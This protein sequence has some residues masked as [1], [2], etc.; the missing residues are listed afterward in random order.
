MTKFPRLKTEVFVVLLDFDIKKIAA[1]R[2]I[3]PNCIPIL[4]V[5]HTRVNFGKRFKFSLRKKK[6][7]TGAPKK[8]SKHKTEVQAV[9]SDSDSDDECNDDDS[10]E[11]EGGDDKEED[12]RNDQ[13]GGVSTMVRCMRCNKFRV[14]SEATALLA[15]AAGSGEAMNVGE[16]VER[17]AQFACDSIGMSCDTPEDEGMSGILGADT[18]E[19]ILVRHIFLYCIYILAIAIR[20]KMFCSF[21]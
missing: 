9:D 8:A 7:G 15:A 1:F 11:S 17:C 13:A 20:Q 3:C 12:D 10:V 5:Y 18:E 14:L 4:C 6:E 16:L 21:N 19:D 2:D